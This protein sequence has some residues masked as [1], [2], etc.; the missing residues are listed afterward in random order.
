MS[1]WGTVVDKW[2]TVD[3]VNTIV[4]FQWDAVGK[5]HTSSENCIK[6]QHRSNFIKCDDCDRRFECWT[7]WRIG[8]LK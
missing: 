5:V 2:D 6:V 3:K 1:E 4:T 8:H 7:S